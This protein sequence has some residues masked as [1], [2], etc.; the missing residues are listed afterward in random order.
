[1]LGIWS[2]YEDMENSL[3]MPELTSLL[4]AKRESQHEERKFFA[5]IQGVD[6]DKNSSSSRG[7]KEW[8]D[9]KA[10]VF[11]GGTV[12]DSNDVVSLQGANA[13]KSGFGI[14][15]GLDYS[16]VKDSKNPKNPMKP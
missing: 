5:A 7:Q 14:G 9:M 13:S 4:V 11:S 2:D 10:R 1:L 3:S 16:S 8:E 15:A 12:K 6:L